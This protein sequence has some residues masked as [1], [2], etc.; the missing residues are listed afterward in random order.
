[1]PF[2]QR[3]SFL[4]LKVTSDF[5]GLPVNSWCGIKLVLQQI[6]APSV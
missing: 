6:A 5:C 4:F 3:Q 2:S 1:M